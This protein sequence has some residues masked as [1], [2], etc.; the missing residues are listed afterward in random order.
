MQAERVGGLHFGRGRVGLEL[1]PGVLL[2]QGERVERAAAGELDSD[3]DRVAGG[4]VGGAGAEGHR[5]AADGA[6]EVGGD[7]FFRQRQHGERFGFGGQG[8]ALLFDLHR[9][10]SRRD[11]RSRRRWSGSGSCKGERDV[12]GAKGER[13]GLDGGE[14]GDQRGDEV[15]GIAD[16]HPP[17][18]GVGGLE[19]ADALGL[20]GAA[21]VLIEALEDV[22]GIG[23]PLANIDLKLNRENLAHIDLLL[24]HS[25]LEEGQLLPG[26]ISRG[27]VGFHGGQLQRLRRQDLAADLGSQGGDDKLARLGGGQRKV[28]HDRGRGLAVYDAEVPGTPLAGDLEIGERR[29]SGDRFGVAALKLER[30][31]RRLADRDGLAIQRRGEGRRAEQRRREAEQQQEAKQTGAAARGGCGGAD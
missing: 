20:Q 7:V 23:D 10:N 17:A 26:R 8:D 31:G 14:G 11:R 19:D 28:L 9:R 12:H 16:A 22:L 25:E 30:Q 2:G 1:A 18:L 4:D 15:D 24:R 27:G 5:E 29:W 13:A 21:A 3:G 6:V